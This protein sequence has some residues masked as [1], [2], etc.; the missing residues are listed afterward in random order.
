MFG[1]V[2][3]FNSIYN[4]LVCHCW[5]STNID[6]QSVEST[7][8]PQATCALHWNCT[9]KAPTYCK[10]SKTSRYET[11][12]ISLPF[13]CLLQVY[14]LSAK[15]PTTSLR[16]ELGEK[17]TYTKQTLPQRRQHTLLLFVFASLLY[18]LDISVPVFMLQHRLDEHAA[19]H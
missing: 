11:E 9:R 12:F 3:S 8:K 13:P 5:C 17:F 15:Q 2:N 10:Y 19:W 1:L 16:L 4:R 7:L 18:L 6:D 14:A